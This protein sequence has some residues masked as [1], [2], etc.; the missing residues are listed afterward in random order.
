MFIIGWI[1]LNKLFIETVA[2]LCNKIIKIDFSSTNN[3]C[4]EGVILIL[5]YLNLKKETFFCP[6]VL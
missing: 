2:V 5:I 6:E 3:K 4:A 1:L